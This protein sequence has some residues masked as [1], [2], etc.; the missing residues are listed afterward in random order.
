[1]ELT[2][3]TYLIVLPL[4]FLAGFV[5][6]VAGGGGIISLPA[7][8]MA[9]IP[10]HLAAGTNK[11]VNGTGTLVAALKYFRSGKVLLRPAVTAAVCALIGSA[12]GTEL[13]V[14]ISEQTLETLMLVALPCVAVFL[15]VKKDFGRDIPAELPPAGR[16]EISNPSPIKSQIGKKILAQ[17]KEKIKNFGSL[18]AWT[19]KAC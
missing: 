4:V 12:V 16:G 9:G 11:V 10:A 15:S 13:A 19:G 8:L 6:S 18:P 3:V 5:D 1:M 7:Y 17:R 14:L 2:P